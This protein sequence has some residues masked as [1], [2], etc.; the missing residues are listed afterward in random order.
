MKKLK[1]FLKWLIKNLRF[2]QGDWILKK[3]LKFFRDAV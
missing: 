3:I 2:N 1:K